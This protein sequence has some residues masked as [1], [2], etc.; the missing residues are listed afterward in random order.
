MLKLAKDTQNDLD[1]PDHIAIAYWFGG[2]DTALTNPLTK[3]ITISSFYFQ[4]LDCAEMRSLLRV[5]IHESIHRTRP[6]INMIKNPFTHP[7]IY[8][9]VESRTKKLKNKLAELCECRTK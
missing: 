7:D 3:N 4:D 8:D 6:R 1:V 2:I 5:I 9:E